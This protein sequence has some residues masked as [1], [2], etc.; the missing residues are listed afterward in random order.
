MRAINLA[1]L[2]ILILSANALPQGKPSKPNE[3]HPIRISTEL[4]Q[5]D[6]VV[7]D[8]KGRVVRGLTKDDFEL[9]EG[10]KKQ[11]INFFEFVEAG[12]ARR[13]ANIAKEH[14]QVSPQGPG[15]ADIKRIFAFVIDDLTIRGVDLVYVREM[16]TN[17]VNNQM[18]PND[19]VAIVRTV[20]GKGLLEQ[21]T[22]D[23]ALL[24][25]AIAALLPSSH[26]LAV[27]NNQSKYG[28]PQSAAGDTFQMLAS[29][30]L[31][32]ST[33]EAVDITNPND[34]TNKAQRASMSLVTASFVVE[35]MKELPGR[36]SLV[37][38]SSGF[39]ILSARPGVD[40]GEIS[41][42]LNALSDKA[43][44]AAVAIHTMDIRGLEAYRA[45]SSF[46]DTPGKSGMAAPGM[47]IPGAEDNFGRD[48]DRAM[49]GNNPADLHQGLR[50]LSSMT[51]GLA[52][53]NKNDFNEG[54]AQIVSSSEAYYLLAYTP[55]NAKFDG[56]FRRVEVKVKGGYRVFSR[57][58]YYARED[59]PSVAPATKQEELIAAMK[60]PLT[61]HDIYLDAMMLYK[62]AANNQGGLDI[63]LIIDPSKLKFE[64][65]ND[66]QQTSFEV[67]G[68]VFDEVGK[69][70]GGFSETVTASLT[71]EEYD[72]AVRAGLPYS[73]NTR[74]PAGAFQVRLAVRD[75]KGGGVGT[76]NR[77]IEVPDLSKGKLAASS[78]LL[79][80]VP[81]NETTATKPTPITGSRQ[82]SRKQDVRYAVIIYNAKQKDG[83]PQVKTQL[84]ISQNGQVISKEQEEAL[85]TNVT[86]SS[87]FIKVGQLGLSSVRPGRY[88]MTLVITDTLAD[89][90]AQT[91]TRSMDFVVVN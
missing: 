74:L 21:F 52:V 53:L 65:V 49:L 70:R 41:Y 15:A 85:Q 86:N 26:P 55:V 63:H 29:R 42:F 51:G 20:G 18:Q 57:R 13:P 33:G 25:R 66:K 9:Y 89:K 75:N 22:T 47:F 68:F 83:K 76:M 62:A 10:G 60:S 56:K 23:K 91:I 14:E 39:P 7:T 88:T 46:E 17:F 79:G 43:T 69:L 37:Y 36:K 64:Q 32:D 82:I 48:P 45:V 80:A 19:L 67:A 8:R 16:L 11:H 3:D 77:Y 1:A 84:T 24:H 28:R 2:S 34:D 50:A 58:G 40:V 27:S 44:R 78:L 71:P 30:D 81:Q 73:A 61:S 90:K 31:V 5:L 72:R 87:Q 54:L 6:A 12:K 38:M 35:S 4:V 59:K